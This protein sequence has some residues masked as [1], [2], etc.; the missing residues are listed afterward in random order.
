MTWN[1]RYA[2]TALSESISNLNKG[3]RDHDET[4]PYSHLNLSDLYLKAYKQV[5]R[6][7]RGVKTPENKNLYRKYKEHQEIGNNLLEE[8]G[9]DKQITPVSPIEEYPHNY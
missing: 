9:W 2:E 4:D 3:L 7:D 6:K 8:Y 5:I 1:L